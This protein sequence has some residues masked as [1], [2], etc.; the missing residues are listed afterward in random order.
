MINQLML[1][2]L[3]IGIVTSIIRTVKKKCIY[4]SLLTILLTSSLLL[5]VSY[6]SLFQVYVY[7]SNL[8]VLYYVFGGLIFIGTMIIVLKRNIKR[9]FSVSI[10]TTFYMFAFFHIPILLGYY[11]FHNFYDKSLVF[12]ILLFIVLL[13]VIYLVFYFV[14]H[15]GFKNSIYTSEIYKKQTEQYRI[16]SKINDQREYQRRVQKM[17]SVDHTFYPINYYLILIVCVVFLGLIQMKYEYRN[18]VE[19]HYVFYYKSVVFE[20]SNEYLEQHVNL[21]LN[22]KTNEDETVD[23]RYVV[24]IEDH[25]T[26]E[27]TCLNVDTL[28]GD[29]VYY[30]GFLYFEEDNNIYVYNNNQIKLIYTHTVTVDDDEILI[31]I[32][33]KKVY[34]ETMKNLYRLSEETVIIQ[35][36]YIS[37]FLDGHAFSVNGHLII[38]TN[39]NST[40][41]DDV[42][43]PVVFRY[44]DVQ[45]YKDF[46][47]SRHYVLK[48]GKVIKEFDDAVDIFLIE[49][50]LY[51][52]YRS[53]TPDNMITNLNNENEILL[54]SKEN[55]S[56]YRYLNNFIV[57]EGYEIIK[58]T[59]IIDSKGYH[60]NFYTNNETV[61]F[62]LVWLAIS[63]VVAS[64]LYFGVNKETYRK[65]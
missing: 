39:M 15:T 14:Y 29:T 57:N 27:E 20:S 40:I 6:M 62:S 50:E 49:D 4:T 21:T 30:E 43:Y 45:F 24:C 22:F 31:Y 33:D 52:R 35:D 36:D 65:R 10:S 55:F 1:I 25:D 59:D 63:Y 23:E 2:L 19:D 56:R 44:E 18:P 42:E 54:Y 38:Q 26:N 48:E 53:S 64:G 61:N 12:T 41:I 9:I 16:S 58:S 8:Q 11:M 47:T 34:L 7:L 32:K 28:V 46:I 51:Y 37:S 13:F 17:N 5:L 60:Y 3:V